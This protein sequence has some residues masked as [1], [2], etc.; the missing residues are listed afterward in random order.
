MKK[1]NYMQLPQDLTTLTST[2][3]KSCVDYLK[4]NFTKKQLLKK[5]RIINAQLIITVEKNM[6]KAINNLCVMGSHI[7][8]A[9][10]NK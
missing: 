3:I 4:K 2:Q 8:F 7:E 6:A 9:M 10:N 5:Q 1:T